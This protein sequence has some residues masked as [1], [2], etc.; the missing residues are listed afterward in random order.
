MG[1]L[2]ANLKLFVCGL[3]AVAIVLVLMGLCGTLFGGYGTI[4]GIGCGA[5][6]IA[7]ILHYFGDKLNDETP[8]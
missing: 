6:A 2:F 1:N 5:A 3:L 8:S 7:A 4:I